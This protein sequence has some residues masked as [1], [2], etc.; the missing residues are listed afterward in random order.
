MARAARGADARA[1]PSEMGVDAHCAAEAVGRTQ[2]GDDVELNRAPATPRR[3]SLPLARTLF[4]PR[5]TEELGRSDPSRSTSTLTQIPGIGRWSAEY[6]LLAR[7]RPFAHFPRRRRGRPQEPRPL[8]SGLPSRSTT[9]ASDAVTGWRPYVGLVYFHLSTDR[10]LHPPGRR[11]AGAL[12]VGCPG[13]SRAGAVGMVRVTASAPVTS[14]VSPWCA[15]WSG[16][17]WRSE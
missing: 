8:D 12:P 6:T 2:V 17:P 9:Q 10:P 14:N 7:A 1:R 5:Y 16:S 3:L 13:R 11:H 4:L 15:I